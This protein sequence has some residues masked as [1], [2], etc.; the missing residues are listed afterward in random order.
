MYR[1]ETDAGAVCL[2][3]WPDAALPVPR[4]LGLHRL[5]RETFRGGVS[6]VAVPIERCDGSTLVS[7]A[8][9]LWQLEPWMPGRA[10]FHS[11]PTV[12]RLRAAM[13]ALAAWHRAAATFQPQLSEAAW[14]HCCRDA[15]SPAVTERLERL[16]DWRGERGRR[17]RSESAVESDPELRAVAERILTAFDRAAPR[18]G[19][20]LRQ[21]ASL[22]FDLQPCLRD[23]WHDHVLFSGDEVTG[24]IDPSACRTEHVAADLSRLIGSLIGDE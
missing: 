9:R 21:A 23:V 7:E 5:L 15:P 13:R 20:E 10:D 3:C 24:L 19:L 6:T 4:I 12:Q 18:I 14:F 8:G 11:H 22:R 1:L 2:R 16:H 17:L